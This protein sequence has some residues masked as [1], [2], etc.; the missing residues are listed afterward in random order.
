M[1]FHDDDDPTR[2]SFDECYTPLVEIKG[3]NAL[4]DYKS[5]FDQ[6]LKNKREAHLELIKMFRNN[7]Y[8]ADNLLDLLDYL[9]HQKY[10]KLIG[11][12]LLRKKISVFLSKLFL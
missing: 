2:N 5:F 8:T 9:Y 3:F 10:C 4:I 11:I 1:H 7:G 6:P 12:D